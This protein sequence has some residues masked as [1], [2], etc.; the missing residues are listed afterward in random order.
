MALRELC[1]RRAERA[2][3]TEQATMTVS[4]RAIILGAGSDI[5][6]GL[7]ERLRRDGWAVVGVPHNA[8]AARRRG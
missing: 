2:V 7:A 5:G 6:R 1:I 8:R 3:S 4:R